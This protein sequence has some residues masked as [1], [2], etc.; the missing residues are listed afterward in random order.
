M[1]GRGREQH[2]SNTTTLLYGWPRTNLWASRDHLC[3]LYIKHTTHPSTR[4]SR[5][6]G[7]AEGPHTLI[8]NVLCNS[9]QQHRPRLRNG[10]GEGSS[11]GWTRRPS[12]T[13]GVLRA[14][15]GEASLHEADPRRALGVGGTPSGGGTRV[16]CPR[17]YG[18]KP[19]GEQTYAR[20][21]PKRREEEATDLSRY[22]H[23]RPVHPNWVRRAPNWTS[24]GA[25]VRAPDTA[26]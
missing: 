2:N 23:D 10:A 6:L 3:V 22:R 25:P 14:D 24:G 9:K 1:R 4:P 13:A 17:G 7:G 8:H 19:R 5:G 26:L 12:R 16:R 21:G 11:G 18:P 20:R 15:P